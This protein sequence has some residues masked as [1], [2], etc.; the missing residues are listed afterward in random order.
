MALA[1]Y[2]LVVIYLPSVQFSSVQFSSVQWLL[3][4]PNL[5]RNIVNSWDTCTAVNVCIYYTRERR[6]M[7]TS[8]VRS[9]PHAT[10]NILYPGA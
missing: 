3:R 9:V 2:V 7:G 1:H 4:M 10:E 6:A 5:P 8:R